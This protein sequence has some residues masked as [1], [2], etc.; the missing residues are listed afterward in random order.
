MSTIVIPGNIPAVCIYTDM[1]LYP[2]LSLFL[3]L[4]LSL[5]LSLILPLSLSLSSS[6]DDGDESL[7]MLMNQ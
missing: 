2:S 5:P 4:S 1:S 7:M 6:D 3:P